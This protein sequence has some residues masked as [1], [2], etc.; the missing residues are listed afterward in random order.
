MFHI[1]TMSQPEK[2]DNSGH[3]EKRFQKPVIVDL[4]F[5]VSKA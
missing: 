4:R 1:T 2:G 3:V 5:G